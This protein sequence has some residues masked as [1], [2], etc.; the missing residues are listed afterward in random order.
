MLKETRQ[1]EDDKLLEHNYLLHCD[2]R[3]CAVLSDDCSDHL[4]HTIWNYVLVLRSMRSD[5]CIS[6]DECDL[7]D[8]FLLHLQ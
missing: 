5:R 8:F 2:P 4:G 7:P 1:S 3:F 6:S